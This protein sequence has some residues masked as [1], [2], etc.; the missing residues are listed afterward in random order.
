MTGKL[1]SSRART[2]T[3][4]L[5][6]QTGLQEWIF[7]WQKS[8]ACKSLKPQG[9][10]AHCSSVS[11]P[12]ACTQVGTALSVWPG[13]EV[14]CSRSRGS[15]TEFGFFWFFLSVSDIPASRKHSHSDG[16]LDLRQK[17]MCSVMKLC[18][19]SSAWCSVLCSKPT[20]LFTLISLLWCHSY[21]CSP[22]PPHLHL[23]QVP[24]EPSKPPTTVYTAEDAALLWWLI[25]VLSHSL[26]EFCISVNH[27]QALK[28]R[29]CLESSNDRY[30]VCDKMF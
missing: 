15:D 9:R 22:P 12:A 26:T 10:W 21:S 3:S 30:N 25:R 8:P 18:D 16:K 13:S 19:H 27:V 6:F 11:Q 4:S 1:N 14:Y 29:N 7:T 20:A 2:F 23:L 17:L 28:R 24:R 5:S